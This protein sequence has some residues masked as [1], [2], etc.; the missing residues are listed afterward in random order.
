MDVGGG[1]LL[2]GQNKGLKGEMWMCD[3]DMQA[4][5]QGRDTWLSHLACSWNFNSHAGLQA[6]RR[7]RA[8]SPSQH[9]HSQSPRGLASEGETHKPATGR[10]RAHP[11]SM[12]AFRTL[13]A[14]RAL[15]ASMH[16]AGALVAGRAGWQM[17]DTKLSLLAYMKLER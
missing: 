5:W 10:H 17:G 2:I 11:A 12:H 9:A 1:G 3:R 7:Y 15:P 8:R 14:T 16:T 6:M 4:G 13:V